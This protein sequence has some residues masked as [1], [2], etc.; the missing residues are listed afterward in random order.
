V[1]GKFIR[2]VGVG[3]LKHPHGV[4]CS[5]FDE[6]VVADNGSSRAVVFSA[7]G[8]LLKTAGRGGF[9]GVATHGG[10]IFA[11]DSVS[12]TCVLFM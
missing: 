9:T 5:A 11:Q 1:D 4:A 3:A 8:E 10:T 2:H 6:L 12:E 7:S